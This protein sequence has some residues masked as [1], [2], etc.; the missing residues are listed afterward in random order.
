MAQRVQRVWDLPIRLFHWLLV[1][2][3]GFSWWSAETHNMEWHYRSGLVL[4]ALL[5][6]RLLWGFIG[7]ATARFAH[8]VKGPRA[9]ATYLRGGAREGDVGHNAI[10]G[11]SVVLI[12][13][14]VSAQVV[15]G[16]FAGDVDGLESGPLSFLISFEATQDVA[17]WHE[18][19]FS[20]LQGL[21]V[22]HVAAIL[23]YQFFRRQ[24]LTTA[25]ITGNRA[26]SNGDPA[27]A[28]GNVP[29]W[30]LI[31]ALLISAGSVYLVQNLA[32]YIS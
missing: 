19:N 14:L 9:V 26:V 29:V 31:V 2:L 4:L 7:T 22:I 1:A 8:F 3:L 6:F 32:K 11:W 21:A 25:M 28:A 15:T 17:D 23:F 30:R 24:N 18:T 27:D 20:L 13:L 5:V 10:G 16:L 12:L